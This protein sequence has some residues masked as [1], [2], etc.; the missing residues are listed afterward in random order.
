M[1]SNTSDAYVDTDI[2][3]RLLTSD[4][5]KKQ[6]AA[7]ILLEKVEKGQLTLLS[8]VT[9]IADAV[10]VLSSPRLYHLSRLKIREVLTPIIKLANFKVE[11]KL[12][13]LAALDLY[14]ATSLDFGDTFLIA[15]AKQ[16]DDGIIYSFDHDFDDIEGIVRKEP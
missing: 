16:S 14:A 7:A 13:V 12:A 2:L 10:Y 6:K 11:S 9:V 1:A 3:I 4:D 15:V 8:P 5:L